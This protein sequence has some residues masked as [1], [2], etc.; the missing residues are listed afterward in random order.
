MRK[1]TM[2]VKAQDLRVGDVIIS[3]Y[4]VTD[5]PREYDYTRVLLDVKI[6]KPSNFSPSPWLVDRQTEVEIEIKRENDD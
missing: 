3:R 5:T 2:L 4:E 6:L 1:T